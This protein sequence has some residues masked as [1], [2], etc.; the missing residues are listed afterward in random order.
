MFPT[1]G[2]PACDNRDAALPQGTAILPMVKP[3]CYKIS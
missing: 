2:I 3:S 1:E